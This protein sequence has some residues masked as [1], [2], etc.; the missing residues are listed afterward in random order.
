MK[1]LIPDRK[2]TIPI[3]WYESTVE[4][5]HV[6]YLRPCECGG[7]EETIY[8]T[9]QKEDGRLRIGGDK[10]FHFSALPYSVEAYTKADYDRE[11]ESDGWYH[12]SLDAYHAGL[13]GDTGWTKNIHPQYRLP[14]GRYPFAFTILT[15]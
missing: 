15:D 5:Q 12:L 2:E 9:L 14:N 10:E 8:L 4:E 6:P 3:G 13:G 11:L 1:R 7:H